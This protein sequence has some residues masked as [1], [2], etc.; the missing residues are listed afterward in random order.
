M[1]KQKKLKTVFNILSIVGP[2]LILFILLFY[3]KLNFFTFFSYYSIFISLYFLSYFLVFNIGDKIEHLLFGF[4]T[5]III[6]T[7]LM[8]N[9]FSDSGTIL[10]MGIV[11]ITSALILLNSP[12]LG[13][14]NEW[15]IADFNIS[16]IIIMVLILF[17]LSFYLIIKNIY[18]IYSLLILLSSFVS[19][20]SMI[21]SFKKDRGKNFQEE[22]RIQNDVSF[23]ELTKKGW[24]DTVII[25]NFNLNMN[26]A[27]NKIQRR[28]AFAV[29]ESSPITFITRRSFSNF[30]NEAIIKVADEGILIDQINGN[31]LEKKISWEEIDHVVRFYTLTIVLKNSSYIDLCGPKSFSFFKRLKFLKKLEI[32]LDKCINNSNGT[33][34]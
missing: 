23:C 22:L 10:I 7:L 33:E 34:T 32:Y 27:G 5:I 17:S 25:P 3:Q 8:F 29:Y 1:L 20:I 24:E 30:D 11:P 19:L 28:N 31:E 6:F 21:Y 15:L 12:S 9:G 18:N 16:S 2:I 26:T 13:K 14:I 4:L